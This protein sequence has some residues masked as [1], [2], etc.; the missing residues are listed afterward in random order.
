M[1]KLSIVALI[2]SLAVYSLFLSGCTGSSTFQEIKGQ[3]LQKMLDSKESISLVD[4]RDA[5]DY[6]KGH[7][8]G[9]IN[10][11]FS[12]F[13]ERSKELK[14]DMKIVLVCYSGGTS[15]SA[16]QFLVSKNYTK[17]SSVKGGM[18]DWSGKL[19]K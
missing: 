15:K 10:I 8:P 14:T 2:L 17:V 6:A 3:E 1:K 13:S 7:I 16:A 18:M 9:A 4:I 12:D 19:T 5:R 11:P